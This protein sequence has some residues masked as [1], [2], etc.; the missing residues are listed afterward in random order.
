MMDNIFHSGPRTYPT[1]QIAEEINNKYTTIPYAANT[2]AHATFSH[3][4]GYGGA[5]YSYLYSNL[6]SLNIWKYC[7]EANPL[8]REIGEQYRREFLAHGGAKEPKEIISNL[9]GSEKISFNVF[10]DDYQ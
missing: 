9:L 4:V 8:S 5:Y 10:L 6:H 7:F 1:T 2:H 3:F